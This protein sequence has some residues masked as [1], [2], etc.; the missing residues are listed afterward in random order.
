MTKEHAMSIVT[1]K[2]ITAEEAE[3][4]RD[5]IISEL[6]GDLESIKDRAD[7]YALDEHERELFDELEDLL[8]LL[9]P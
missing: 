5:K 7:W 6:G 1:V 4:R 9:A 3:K 8:Y 2:R